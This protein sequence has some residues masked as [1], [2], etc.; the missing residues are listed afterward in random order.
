MIFIRHRQNLLEIKLIIERKGE[1]YLKKR[2][3]REHYE[4][5]SNQ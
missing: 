1:K 2:K 5:T 3:V 4:K